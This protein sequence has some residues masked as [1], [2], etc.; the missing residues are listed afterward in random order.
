MMVN[1]NDNHG[2]Q[3]HNP[4]NA[5]QGLLWELDLICTWK[6]KKPKNILRYPISDVNN[7]GG[8]EKHL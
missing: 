1:H 6:M 3:C 2:T 5:Q 4:K 8:V 7:V